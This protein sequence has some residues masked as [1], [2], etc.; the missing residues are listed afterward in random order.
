MRRRLRGPKADLKA[1]I[2][3]CYGRRKILRCVRVC[4]AIYKPL[5]LPQE[6]EGV[7]VTIRFGLGMQGEPKAAP[8]ALW[9]MHSAPAAQ[10]A[11]EKEKEGV[12]RNFVG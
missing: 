6:K 12:K 1:F 2:R 8:G 11:Q 7:R 5:G 3:L 4:F 9:V 10:C